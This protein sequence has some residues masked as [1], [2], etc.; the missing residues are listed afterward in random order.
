MSYTR[1]FKCYP[2]IP[3]SYGDSGIWAIGR[4]VGEGVAIVLK[5]VAI[6]L[7]AAGYIIWGRG[8]S[9]F[10]LMLSSTISSY[11]I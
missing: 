5:G 11:T 7:V 4:L 1:G 9:S 6:V 3:S 2:I 10:A 8:D